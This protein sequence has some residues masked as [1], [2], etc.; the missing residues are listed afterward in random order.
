MALSLF[1]LIGATVV[2]FFERQM[3]FR[4][5]AEIQAEMHQGLNA[6]FDALI[7]DIRLAGACLPRQPVF[8]P[9]DGQNNATPTPD[10][11]TLRTGVVSGNTTCVQATLQTATAAGATTVSVDNLTG[12]TVNKYAFI[13]GTSNGEYFKVQSLSGSSGAGTITSATGLVNAY[14]VASGVYAIQERTYSID[15]VNLPTTTN[16]VP[17]L[18]VQIDRATSGGQP[19]RVPVA[20]NID[21]LDIQYRENQGCTPGPCTVVDI[22][23]DNATWNQVNAVFITMRARSNVNQSTNQPSFETAGPVAVQPRNFL[24]FRPN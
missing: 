18:V 23:T 15:T 9:M 19:S 24:A 6:A 17:T 16:P 1:G 2:N 11:I 22:P 14:P 5:D 10:T 3:K 12:F 7:R 20:A 4:G 8:V 21:R 13:N